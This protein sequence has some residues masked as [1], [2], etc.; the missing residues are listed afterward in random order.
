MKRFIFLILALCTF[1][2]LSYGD[3]SWTSPIAISTALADTSDPQVVI[4]SNGNVT[5]V[6]VENGMIQVCYKTSGGSWSVPA[7]LSTLFATASNPKLGIDS[8]GNVTALWI[9]N[10]QIKSAQLIG[11]LWSVGILIS[12]TGALDPSLAVDANGNAVAVW[13]RN[14]FIESSTRKLGLW[15]LFSTRSAAN[16][17][18]PHVAISSFGTAI[19]AWHS[20]VAGADVIVTDILTISTNTWAPTKNVFNGTAAVLHNYPIVAIDANGNANVAWFRYNILNGKAFQNVQV[21]VSSLATGAAA[22]SIPAILSNSGIRNPADLTIKLA[23]D[24]SGNALA[25][26]T[27]S[28]DG[29]IFSV[30]SAQKLFGATWPP[31]LSVHI[32]TLYSFGID[33]SVAAGNGLMTNMAWDGTSSMLIQSQTTDTTN[34]ILQAWTIPS[35]VSTGNSNAYPKCAIT[36][37]GNTFKTA[38]VWIHFDGSNNVIHASTGTYSGIASPS[39]VQVV[40][41]EIDFGVYID[42]INRITWDPSPDPNIIQYNIYR[43]GIFINATGP[44][45]L[46]FFDHN[47]VQGETV[48]YGVAAITSNYQ[49]STTVSV[50]FP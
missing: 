17:N 12:S 7:T 6:W 35:L 44:G 20:V 8:S 43:N 14:G 47:G 48:I 10:T 15:S 34:P 38:A 9:E 2:R 45:I 3:I 46:E 25:V 24:A 5:A 40:Q 21:I 37:A 22:W 50:S 28:Y 18:N 39:N 29:E 19:A 27:N 4:D 36:L 49:Q 30:E 41:S 1:S 13:V 16:S 26:W 33:L 23:F 31:L 32:P 42:Y 11:G